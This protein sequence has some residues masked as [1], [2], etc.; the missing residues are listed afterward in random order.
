MISHSR[1]VAVSGGVLVIRSHVWRL[2]TQ[3]T[4]DKGSGHPAACIE[5]TF[6]LELG[7]PVATIRTSPSQKSRVLAPLQMHG[8]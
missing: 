8:T 4:G 2:G 3:L 5:A 1:I 6:C 7:N